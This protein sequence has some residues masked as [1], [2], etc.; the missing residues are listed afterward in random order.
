MS[1]YAITTKALAELSRRAE[2]NEY[3]RYVPVSWIEENAAPD[4]WHIARPMM[5]RNDGPES[6]VEF[7]VKVNKDSEAVTLFMDCLV[8][9]LEGLGM[10]ATAVQAKGWN[11]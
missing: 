2:A 11:A 7:M 5:L 4:G 3:H 6:I 9:D 10:R 1:T 8:S